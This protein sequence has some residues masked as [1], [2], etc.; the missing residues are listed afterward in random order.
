M[1]DGLGLRQPA[2]AFLATACC[3]RSGKESTIKTHAQQQAA[4]AKAAAGCRSPKLPPSTS[5]LQTIR[6]AATSANGPQ[7]PLPVRASHQLKRSLV[8]NKPELAINLCRC[9]SHQLNGSR[10]KNRPEWA[11]TTLAGVREPPVRKASR[12]AQ[13][14]M[15]RHNDT[16]YSDKSTSQHCRHFNAVKNLTRGNRPEWAATTLAGVREPPVRRVSR[17]EKA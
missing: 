9:A 7:Q 12:Q 15:G 1:A 6:Q 14:R 17:S 3:G 10:V 2:A 16:G 8:K 5:Q 13:A 4:E 11:A